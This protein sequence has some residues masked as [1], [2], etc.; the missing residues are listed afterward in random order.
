MPLV[1]SW[2]L[3]VNAGV[4]TTVQHLRF[5]KIYGNPKLKPV[6]SLLLLLMSFS[7][8]F[9]DSNLGADVELICT[10][11]ISAASSSAIQL[12]FGV[13][14]RSEENTGVLTVEIYAHSETNYLDAASP[15]LIASGRLV[16]NLAGS[17]SLPKT[18]RRL[19]ISQPTPGDYYVSMVLLE[20]GVPVDQTRSAGLATFA[21]NLP[22]VSN[23][24]GQYFVGDPSLSIA[25]SS[26]S[27]T[28]PG[29][30][31]GTNN[32]QPLQIQVIATDTPRLVDSF[33]LIDAA[34]P[35][36]LEPRSESPAE[37][38]SLEFSDPGPG[39]PFYHVLIS[40]EEITHLVHTVQSSESFNSLSFSE[41]S[42]D[43]LTDSDGDG[44]AD[45][46][47]IL[48]GTDPNS[49]ASTPGATTIDVLA[50]YN[51]D[52]AAIYGGDPSTRIDALTTA[53]NQALSDS[54]VNMTINVV[55]SVQLGYSSA[56]AQATLL[57]QAE[58]LTG[59]FSTLQ[60]LRDTAEADLVVIFTPDD[61]A[62][63]C[64]TATQGG[65]PTQGH[66]ARSD[67]ISVSVIADTDCDDMSMMHGIGH[68]MGLNHSSDSNSSGTFIWARGHGRTEV[69]ATIMTEP[70]QFAVAERLPYF[71]DPDISL[72]NAAPC[73]IAIGESEEANAAAA[74]NAVRF[75]VGW[76]SGTSGTEGSP[77][78]APNPTPTPTPSNDSDG[79]GV[80]NG[81]DAFPNDPA[82]SVDTDNDGIGNNADTDDD[83]D[84]MPDEWELANG[85]NSL[86]DDTSE[87]PDA[88]GFTNIQEYNRG[89]DPQVPDEADACDDPGITAPNADDS[90]LPFER[91]LVMVN[92]GSNTV[93]Q[94]FIRLINSG[95]SDT[96][97]EIYG[98]D[99]TGAYSKNAPV[100]LLLGAGESLQMTSQDLENGNVAKGLSSTLCDLEGKW[101]L[102]VR[103]DQPIDVMG[104]IRSEN[105][106]LTGMSEIASSSDGNHQ[107]YFA[108]PARNVNQQTFLRI[109]NLDNEAGQVTITGLDDEGNDPDTS[110]RFSLIAN[111]SL[112]VTSQDLENGNATKGLTGSLGPAIGKWR[113]T[114]SSDR[115][116]A[117]MSL[118]R[119]PGGFLTNMSALTPRNAAN[120]PVAYFV[121]PASQTD[122]ET[123]LR[124]VNTTPI[125]TTITLSATD[126]SGHVAPNGDILLTLA[127]GASRQMTSSDLETG[128]SDKGL[129]GFFGD[130]NGNWKVTVSADQTIEVMSLVRTTDG[131]L[132]NMSGTVQT[133]DLQGQA[134]FVN[135]ASNTNQQSTLRIINVSDAQGA[136]TI[137]AVDDSG[138][139]APGGD[140]TFNLSAGETRSIS[141][142]ELESGASD[143]VGTLG[144]GTG[145]WR[146]SVT[147]DV[148]VR[149]MSLIESPGGYVT[150]LSES[151]Q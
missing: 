84:G 14:N 26:M 36:T 125:S 81:E 29:V 109:T 119:A 78:P 145:K 126:D 106:F 41:T 37:L 57:S 85:L 96:S 107:V 63:V 74:L 19:P 24:T 68:N 121:S 23:G 45:D 15:H 114:V 47:E 86:V 61:D 30:G 141:S 127:P 58:N 99:D 136:I 72:C 132:T 31:N 150:N 55:D 100:S 21:H 89:S 110:V 69:F 12:D 59:V 10:C 17:N 39:F 54:G 97:I 87:D 9:G 67:H 116:L 80:P 133:V 123:F 65:Y 13:I 11:D 50:V 131:F 137:S 129:S 94:S 108:N 101:Q 111:S 27:L 98:I 71:S 8:V 60:T 22:V 5:H 115:N 73:G 91:R 88:D 113:F 44:V 122:R 52:V 38:F 95:D 138:N 3:C 117:V 134:S 25:G 79:D 51:A 42:V 28:L 105:G 151:V 62:G 144:D 93:R 139:A 147:S 66:L 128:N 6:T 18:A 146:I 77:S 90:N 148:E 92:P 102:R 2:A 34:P 33:V 70:S 124:I 7:P 120:D 135:P 112:Q 143:L 130:G 83:N 48:E 16:N 149:I 53:S 82:E 140:V 104:L 64:S 35:V 76:F 20:D 4:Q 118:I 142:V 32:N 43:Y 46:N 40:S 56:T 75:Q 1:R 103:S 49:A